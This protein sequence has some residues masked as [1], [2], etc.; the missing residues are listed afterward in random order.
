V[1]ECETWQATSDRIEAVGVRQE[2]D[3]LRAKLDR[4]R[5]AIDN[6]STAMSAADGPSLAVQRHD[7]SWAAWKNL[8]NVLSD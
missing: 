4:L 2:R 5:L 7:P 6:L 1:T 8:C 3:E